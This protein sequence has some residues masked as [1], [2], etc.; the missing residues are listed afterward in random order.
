MR[1][2]TAID[3]DCM[4]GGRLGALATDAASELDVLGLDRDP[5]G[6]DGLQVAVLK[7]MDEVRLGRFLQR[8]DGLRR[9]PSGKRVPAAMSLATTRTSRWKGS[10]HP[11]LHGFDA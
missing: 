9:G 7:E 1:L 3:G 5:L 2:Q 6:V 4:I 10:L 11:S 8:D